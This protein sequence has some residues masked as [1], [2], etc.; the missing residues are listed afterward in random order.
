MARNLIVVLVAAT[1][2]LAVPTVAVTGSVDDAGAITMA[3]HSGPNGQYASVTGGEIEV[4]FDALNDDAV[5]TADDVFNVTNDADEP[6]EVWVEIENVTAY[7]H[8]DPT[9]RV[10]SEPDAVVLAPNETLQVGFEL[11]TTD[12]VPSP[13]SMTVHAVGPSDVDGGSTG[14]AGSEQPAGTPVTDDGGPEMETDV[15]VSN[16]S[17]PTERVVTVTVSNEGDEAGT[18]TA[19]PTVDGTPIGT[20]TV[21]LLPGE[22]RR[23]TFTY[24][25]DGAGT[26]RVV[27][28]GEMV[29]VTVAAGVDAQ[30]RVTDLAVPADD[31]TTGSET[32]VVATVANDGS[33]S[34]TYTAVL[35]DDGTIVA[36]QP[37]TVPAGEQRTVSFAV[38]FA[39]P[40]EHELRVGDRRA[41]VT[42]GGDRTIRVIDASVADGRVA[43][44][45][46]TTISA[47]VENTGDSAGEIA[48]DLSVGGV[49]V[50]AVSVAVPAGETRTVTIQHRFETPGIYLVSVGDASAG[51]VVVQSGDAT[52]DRVLT[53]SLGVTVGLPL[54]VG[55][56]LALWRRRLLTAL[57]RSG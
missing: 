38:T 13:G 28:D 24:R 54:A 35:L 36:E 18:Y 39:E 56:V 1:L 42:V 31:V 45:N 7:R 2:L 14:D 25:F 23:L 34:G 52:A 40:G 53:S 44:G 15:T 22:T 20:Q 51:E 47:T 17:A 48:L 3:P 21:T 6:A 30:F 19:E 16:G 32:S 50:D 46:T 29:R 43:P 5:T 4:S 26:Y 41:T 9:D 12:V 37:V 10:D 33:E 11:D 8:D 55:V 57:L 27:V 49:V